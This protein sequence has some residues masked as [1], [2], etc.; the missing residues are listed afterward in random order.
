[1][2]TEQLA[3][4]ISTTLSGSINNSVTALS[5]TSATGFPSSGNFR[6][7][8]DSEIMTVTA[9]S[10]TTLTVTRGAEGTTAASHT[11]GA[12]ITVVLT[13]DAMR[14]YR[15]D[16]N[17]FDTLA[18]QPSAAIVNRLYKPTDFPVLK[19]D[20]GSVWTSMY[21]LSID[22]TT[23]DD[24]SF[25]WVNQG[26]ATVDTSKYGTYLESVTNGNADNFR[27]RVKTHSSPKK[28]T[29][30]FTLHFQSDATGG[31]GIVFRESS[32]SKFTSM[33]IWG[34]ASN[35]IKVFVENWTNNTTISGSVGSYFCSHILN[36]QLFWLQMED[37]GTNIYWRHSRDGYKFSTATFAPV[38]RTTFMAG[39]P[40]QIGYFVNPKNQEVGMRVIS[41]KEE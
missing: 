22:L 32:T 27:H 38:G 35:L 26:S 3:N 8:I 12:T 36:D 31:G 20:T 29:I 33:T 9:R 24:S 21:G 18:N 14:A 19:R 30:G 39:G 16:F 23:P 13:A 37:D 4:N 15:E 6:I 25:S 17:F 40:N 28:Y 11:S 41:W 2:A 34:N 7:F 10:G 1:M 5:L